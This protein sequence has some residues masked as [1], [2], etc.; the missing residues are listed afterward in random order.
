[1]KIVDDLR[2][3]FFVMLLHVQWGGW[4]WEVGGQ[5]NLF[6][7]DDILVSIQSFSDEDRY[8]PV[9]TRELAGRMWVWWGVGYDRRSCPSR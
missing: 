8:R 5:T 9:L 7:V 6:V 3:G 1:M 4:R 2:V